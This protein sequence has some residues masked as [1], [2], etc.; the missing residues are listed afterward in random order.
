MI[1]ISILRV[2]ATREGFDK[3]FSAIPLKALETKTR[4]IVSD[5]KRY[6]ETYT[7]DDKIDFVLFRDS[8]HRWH[9]T[10]DAEAITYYDKILRHVEVDIND[11]SR[12]VLINSMIELQLATDAAQVLENYN[13]GDEISV[14]HELLDLAESARAA[15][16]RKTHDN[17]IKP[18]MDALIDS[19]D[20]NHGLTWRLD[21]LNSQLRP[22][23]GGD[24]IL[25]AGRPDTGK[26]TFITDNVTHM[27]TQVD[28]RP[29]LWLNNE[30]PGQRIVS[31]MIQSA[32]AIDTDK[33]KSLHEEGILSKAY[34][35][36][37]GSI[38]RIR[39]IDIH[40][41]WNWQV[42]E[43][44]E[45][46]QPKLV[47]LDMIDNIKFSGL[48]LHDG[49]RTDQI[50]ESM[51]QWARKQGVKYDC[52]M[53]ATSQISAD[54]EGMKY[55]T[56]DMLKDSKTGKQGALDLQIMIGKSDAPEEQYYRYIGTPK[57][58]LPRPGKQA[59]LRHEVRF[60]NA[61]ARYLELGVYSE[62]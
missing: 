53:M 27:A 52:V 32:L 47:I 25:I 11:V 59:Y 30:G 8:F 3:M 22:M 2:M 14:I 5:I 60:D 4:V 20:V 9:P 56:M 15:T 26:T 38:D 17:W 61:Q 49:A 44:I 41:Y 7:D 34:A 28:T 29:I 35:D 57:N 10:L 55:P 37:I 50:L 58:K 39:V 16:Q 43:L 54:G 40:D 23:V 48:S 36:S 31:R 1:E 45:A 33:M 51:Y 6:Y 12:T 13:N 62:T 21:Y 42:A 46:H 19:M 24:M 18:D